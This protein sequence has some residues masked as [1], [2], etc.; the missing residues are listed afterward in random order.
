M[1]QDSRMNTR[2]FVR[3]ALCMAALLSP[4]PL[5]AQLGDFNPRAEPHGVY[6]IRDARIVP[7]TGPVIE[8]GNI[9]IGVDGRI[10][11]VGATAAIPNGAKTID[12]SGLTVYPGM[13]ETVSTLGLNEIPDGVVQLNDASESG[14]FNP[15]VHAIF[16][17]N[18]HSAHIGVTRVV[19]ITHMVSHP[20]GG[21]LAGQ[22]TLVNLSGDNAN[23]MAMVRDIAMVL[24]MPR[25]G[26]GGGRGGRGGGGAATA[27]APAGM[28]P[29]DSLKT[30]LRDA[31]AYATAQ[32][33]YARDKSLPRPARDV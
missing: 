9:V 20:T 11:A 4:A 32:E 12:G 1:T 33:A 6:A 8:R 18:S 26:G 25:A 23:D 30:M 22:A 27:P 16:G 28:T 29:L 2:T 15:N 24:T 14:S 5:A 21:V 19:G 10:Q 3:R 17:L 31:D 13:M 7:V